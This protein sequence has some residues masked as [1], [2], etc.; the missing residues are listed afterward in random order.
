VGSPTR[1]LVG[2]NSI[3]VP[4]R[5]QVSVVIAL[6][7]LSFPADLAE[8]GV[9]FVDHAMV[10]WRRIVLCKDMEIREGVSA[11]VQSR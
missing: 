8:M 1:S 4:L 2:C 7:H 5:L 11:R 3:L 9:K 10:D 6:I